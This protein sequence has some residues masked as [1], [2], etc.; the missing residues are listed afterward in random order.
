M[1][2]LYN[3]TF[4]RLDVKDI[5]NPDLS[6]NETRFAEIQPILLTPYFALSY[7]VSFAVLTSA[8][9]TVALWH[10][11]D[12]KTAFSNRESAGDIHVESKFGSERGVVELWL[13]PD[14]AS[15]RTELSYHPNLV[16][17]SHQKTFFHSP[18]SVPRS[19]YLTVFASMLGAAMVLVTF[20]PLQLPIWGLILSI[21]M[22]VAFLVPVGVRLWT[23]W[24][25]S[26]L[27]R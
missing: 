4:G 11:D 9:T 10:W 8:I 22:A 20:Y 13:T 26:R 12:I 1:Q 7:G 16:R 27:T 17:S 18:T 15:A 23:F 3:S 14:F 5:L 24:L 21:M 6:L 25:I 2:H 19:Y